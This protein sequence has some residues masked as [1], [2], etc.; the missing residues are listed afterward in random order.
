MTVSTLTTAPPEPPAHRPRGILL[1]PA[2]ALVLATAGLGGGSIAT[3]LTATRFEQTSTL[4]PQ[5]R[6]LTVRGGSG[7]IEV[8]P[9]ADGD[10]HVTTRVEYQGERPVLVEESTPDGVLLRHSCDSFFGGC[11]VYYTVG[12]PAGVV[13]DLDSDSGE[14]TVSGTDAAVTARASSGS[15]HVIDTG[16]AVDAATDS[17]DVVVSGADGA[18][19]AHVGSGQV[20]VVDVRAGVVDVSADSGAITGHGLD[21]AT[22]RARTG[23]GEVRLLF[24]SPPSDVDVDVDSGPV[25]VAVPGS[26]PYAVRTATDGGEEHIGVAIDPGAPRSIDVTTGSGS[27][28]V[29]A[30]GTPPRPPRP[31]DAPDLPQLPAAPD[32]PQL[33]SPPEP[34]VPPDPPR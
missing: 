8:T 26:G 13:L 1:V 30:V 6:S 5:G 24:V 11:E 31:P 27:I 28:T 34:P 21:A 18:V 9:S 15:V 10:V 32:L 7:D 19:T 12:V 3:Q 20:R 29:H 25:T 2:V 16:A 4:T 14:I 17:G 33:P 22:V 23:S